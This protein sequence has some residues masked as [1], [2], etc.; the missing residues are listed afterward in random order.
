MEDSIKEI[1]R[2]QRKLEKTTIKL[3][4][5]IKELKDICPHEKTHTAD[6]WDSG[7]YFNQSHTQYTEIC[8]TCG[9]II[10]RWTGNYGDFS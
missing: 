6:Y 9:M 2:L 10:K 8:T 4:I 1:K 3:N 7:S 5:A